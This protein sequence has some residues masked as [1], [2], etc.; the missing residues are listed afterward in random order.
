MRAKSLFHECSRRTFSKGKDKVQSSKNFNQLISKISLDDSN[1]EIEN[2]IHSDH[3]NKNNDNI[4]IVNEN[5]LEKEEKYN[6]IKEKEKST[7]YSSKEI[8][9]NENEIN[10]QEKDVILEN[11]I[12]LIKNNLLNDNISDISEEESIIEQYDIEKKLK[13]MNI[14][15]KFY[16]YIFHL[17]DPKTMKIFFNPKEYYFWNKFTIILKYINTNIKKYIMFQL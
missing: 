7:K 11:E 8:I 13:N 10:N 17:S 9:K 14:P 15:S 5:E 3:E 2:T 4:I 6:S 12:S 16:R 1:S